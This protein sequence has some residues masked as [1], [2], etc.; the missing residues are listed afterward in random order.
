[1][2]VE[3]ETSRV[4]YNGAGTT[5]PFSIPFYFLANGDI[6]AIKVTIA[7]GTEVELALTTDFTLTGAGEEAGGALTLVASLSSSFRLVI[8]R[9]PE[10]LQD[11]DYPANDA[12]PSE[13]HEQVA[14]LAMMIDQR[15]RELVSRSMRQPDGDATD[16]TTIP[17]AV[18]RASMFL[19][20][21]GD[22]EP[23]ASEAPVAGTGTPVSAFMAT[24][25]DDASA[26]A[27]FATMIAAL[28]TGTFVRKNA[29]ING[30]FN[31]WQ[32]GT[33]FAAIANDEYSADC[34]QYS[35][36]GAMVHT[37]SRSTDVPTVAQAGRLFNYSLLIDCTTADAS[38]AAGDFCVL[39][40]PLEGFN[41]APLAQRIT[42]LSF[43]VKATKTGI[44]CIS[45][46]NSANDR[47]CVA[48]YT[49]STTETW[50]KKEITFPASPSDGT[51]NYTNGRGLKVRFTLAVGS[52]FQTPA[53][54]WTTGHFIGSANQVN[55]T[56]STANNFSVC[57]VQFEAGS[58]ATSFDYRTYQE[59]LG[60]CERYFQTWGG[61]AAEE[62]FCA[63]TIGNT[64]TGALILPYKREML[65]IPTLAVSAVGDFHLIAGI[66]DTVA[67]V[68]TMGVNGAGLSSAQL[69]V[70]GTGTPYTAAQACIL[71]ANTT[72]ARLNLSAPLVA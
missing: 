54:A 16:I 37:I 21:D 20:F 7:D 35:K 70:T 3:S 30:D 69:D 57:G 65:S 53:G 45:L 4:T 22:G 68:I 24:V 66:T 58:V 64:S 40:Y 28:S 9:D 12:F 23:I 26:D 18:E 8:F 39:Q 34:W 15:T 48:E 43:W 29:I 5:G 63:G 38:I 14:D 17:P 42:T 47:A 60:L 27:V 55:A 33:S 59:E 2:T 13:T 44:Y 10:L 31:V 51:W 36:T 1:M 72:A 46:Q 61:A 50:E 71:R 11:A 67:T 25:L 19:A 32:R 49:I 62:A 56:D 52:T 41:W 6:R